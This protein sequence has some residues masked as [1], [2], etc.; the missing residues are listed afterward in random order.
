MRKLFF[1]TALAL[2]SLTALSAAP[3]ILNDNVM[4]IV[5]IG[6]FQEISTDQLPS[7]VKQAVE[8]DY[9]GASIDKAYVND[10][11]QYKLE[12]STDDGASATLYA[13]S[14]GNWLNM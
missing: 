6:D 2:G 9:E 12:I 13:D 14:E 5:K 8:R 3:I 7:A 1:A 10:K 4:E 11:E